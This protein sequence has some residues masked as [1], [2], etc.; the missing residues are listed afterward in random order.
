MVW[1]CFEERRQ[2][3]WQESVEFESWNKWERKNKDQKEEDMQE[4]G[5]QPRDA[6]ER[7][8]WSRKIRTGNPD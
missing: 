7:L 8:E 2:I 3:S 5:V 4:Q 1:T 6:E